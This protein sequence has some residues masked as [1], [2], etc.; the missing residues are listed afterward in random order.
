[1]S[2][3]SPPAVQA[4][5]TAVLSRWKEAHRK[6]KR[7]DGPSSSG[8]VEEGTPNEPSKKPK[9]EEEGSKSVKKETLQTASGT[10]TPVSISGGN[11]KST[12]TR[13]KTT[14]R[15]NVPPRTFKLDKPSS[16]SVEP[17]FTD[18]ETEKGM[19]L[20]RKAVILFYDALAAD[21]SEEK[22]RLAGLAKQLESAVFDVMEGDTGDKYRASESCVSCA[23]FTPF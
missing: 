3:K 8:P 18:K 22:E 5:A 14:I 23:T 16:T 17:K 11:T 15:K 20:R 9:V 19:E 21:S 12:S 6:R 7:E 1:M 2:K 13:R 4:A 10:S